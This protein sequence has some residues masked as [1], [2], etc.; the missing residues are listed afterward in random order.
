M[1]STQTVTTAALLQAEKQVVA[2]VYGRLMA[3]YR[4][5]FPQETVPPLARAVTWALFQL[6]PEDAAAIEF[7][8]LHRG[9][10]DAEVANLREDEEIR[11]IVTDTIVLKAVF[12]HRQRG[13]RDVSSM[14]P[15]EHLKKL[16]IFLEGES[17][18]TPGSFVKTAEAFFGSTLW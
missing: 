5:R 13:C 14:E 10:I 7:M 17:P 16:G 18:P 2:G 6:D 8:S 12:L 9:V 3:R 11:R 15:I 4:Q 1:R